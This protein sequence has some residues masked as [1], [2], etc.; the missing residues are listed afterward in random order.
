[1]GALPPPSDGA[2][3]SADGRSA[4]VFCY[5]RDDPFLSGFGVKFLPLQAVSDWQQLVYFYH[6]DLRNAAL[7][8]LIRAGGIHRYI[9]I[10]RIE[11]HGTNCFDG[12]PC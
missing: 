7:I 1:M 12:A 10:L 3:L 6:L 11:Y 8:P 9:G 4:Y 2:A 5:R